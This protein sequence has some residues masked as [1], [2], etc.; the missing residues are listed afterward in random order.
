M[1]TLTVLESRTLPRLYFHRT[2][3]KLLIYI[4]QSQKGFLGLVS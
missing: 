3:P 2:F 1:K 4:K